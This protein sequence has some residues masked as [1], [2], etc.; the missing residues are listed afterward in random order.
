MTY[1]VSQGTFNV[2]ESVPAGWS[3]AS[4]TCTNLTINGNTP[5]VNGVPTL[6]CAITNTKMAKLKIVKNA[7][8]QDSQDFGYTTTGTGL[9]NFS[10]DDDN[11]PTLPNYKEF[12]VVPGSYSV[13]EAATPGWML[14]DLKC[15][16]RDFSVVGS[17]VT[18]QL[19][20]GDY[21]VCTYENAKLVSLGGTKYEVN[22]DG[23]T[24]QAE[25]SGW[26]IT[27]LKDGKS[28]GLT[29]TTDTNGNY[30]FSGLLPGNYNVAE[31]LKSGW[32]QIYS[33]LNPDC[34]DG[35]STTGLNFGNFRNGSIS[36]YKF[37]DH[38]GNGAEDSGDEHLGGWTIK[39]YKDTK[40]GKVQVGDPVV[41]NADGN[42][43]FT[44]LGPGT[45]WVCEVQQS[46]WVQ[47]YPANNACH[48]VVIDKSGESN[49]GT[50]FG[51][52]GQGMLTVK[53]NVDSNGDGTVDYYNVENWVWDAGGDSHATGSAQ[54]VAAGSYTVT[55]HQ[56]AG[57]HF[58]S[59]VCTGQEKYAQG[60]SVN[61]YV[62]PGQEVVCTFTNTRDTGWIKVVKNLYPQHDPG[63][64]NLLVDGTIQKHD[65]GNGDNT[66]WVRVV[67]GD[68]SVAETAGTATNADNYDSSYACWAES[69]QEGYAVY[70][71]D[72]YWDTGEGAS[73]M[74]PVA[75]G[76]NIV[77]SFYNER[78]SSLTIHKT[79]QPNGSQDFTFDV[80]KVDMRDTEKVAADVSP[81]ALEP[82]DLLSVD[83]EWNTE[84][85]E[86]PLQSFALDDD[87]DPTLSNQKSFEL[88]SGWYAFT[89]SPTDGWDMTGLDCGDN[90]DWYVDEE[91]GVLYVWLQP[92][93]NMDCTFTN[94]QRATVT[95]VKDA[96]PDFGQPFAFTTNLDGEEE[97]TF[98]LTDD[99]V[100]PALAST[101]FSDVLAGSYTVAEL[102]ASGWSLS[103]ASCS[104]AEFTK[105]GAEV[106]LE[107]EPGANVVCTF[108]NQKNTVPQVLGE[109]TVTPPKLEATGNSVWVAVAMS[110]TVVGLACLTLFAR[111]R[112]F[113]TA[114]K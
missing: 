105:D 97:T 38:N 103:G 21:V 2:T 93:S 81:L 1:E 51:N 16:N 30:T 110:A 112:E 92:G 70:E 75:Y 25:P 39:L 33:P 4:N 31:T 62:A 99:G 52:N 28:T 43:S 17:K 107:V 114:L 87:T 94:T 47:T 78:H 72:G 86:S 69:N 35:G 64:F 42:F 68:H 77:C 56:K 49:P 14:S 48:K 60:E 113:A 67:T 71:S 24:V 91:T 106:S 96:R 58:T 5:L 13:T 23:S 84:S 54:S 89:E 53:K 65:A 55:E 59:V 45:Y 18:V 10:L 108:V 41:T 9:S 79:A 76:Q 50:K 37:S 111:R 88:S 95:I 19:S 80:W 7:S 3:Q 29:Q 90:E 85:D 73:A 109:V 63:R 6:S 20:A 26:V 32:T 66:G 101:T 102:V 27:L 40:D 46:G 44:N 98:S 100:N 36:G 12:T 82:I 57:Y 74:V 83:S 22:A 15:N 8:P 104:G 61:V 34:Q 11:N